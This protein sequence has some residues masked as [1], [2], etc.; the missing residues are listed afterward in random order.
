MSEGINAGRARYLPDPQQSAPGLILLGLAASVAE[1]GGWLDPES[2]AAMRKQVMAGVL[3]D[4]DPR[5]VWPCFTRGL[6]AEHP[7]AMFVALRDCG[8]LTRLL[9]ELAALFGHFQSA[10]DSDQVDIG[11]HQLRV[12]DETAK[13][14]APLPVRVAALLYNLGKSDSPPQHLPAHYKH[15][16]R[17]LPRIAAIAT[18]FGIPADTRALAVLVAEELERVHRAAPMRAASITA[19]LERVDAFGQAERFR[20]LMLVCTCDF[21]AYEGNAEKT[22]PKAGL[23][24]RALEACQKADAEHAAESDDEPL[25]ST[26]R[27]ELRALA[28]ARALGSERWAEAGESA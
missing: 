7:S 10:S 19:L 4:I 9:P 27:H 11:E 14:H 2:L 16:D 22:Y 23:L 26:A 25:D 8:A 18:R 13:R 24:Q 21:A 15:V 28:V 1:P 17:C 12:L 5:D 6:M 20:D 3:A